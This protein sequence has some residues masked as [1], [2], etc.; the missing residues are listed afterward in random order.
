[1]SQ[2]E[3]AELRRQLDELLAKGW[4]PPSSLPYGHPILFIRK[5]SGELR[6]CVDYRLLN[7]QTK[8]DVYPIPRIDAL[9]DSLSGAAVFSLIDL[10]AGY[11]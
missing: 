9:L 8:Q 5:K 6:M 11:H 10:R 3:L 2:L 7:K 4:I 1:M